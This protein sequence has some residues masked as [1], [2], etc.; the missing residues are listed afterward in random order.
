[1]SEHGKTEATPM[2]LDVLKTFQQSMNSLAEKD[3]KQLAA[4]DA[5]LP[6]SK[7]KESDTQEAVLAIPR[8]PDS[9][10]LPSLAQSQTPPN[11]TLDTLESKTSEPGVSP[12]SSVYTKDRI[13]SNDS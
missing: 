6:G 8:P 1:M 3:A 9:S 12:A 13:K 10:S 7:T 2:T 4:V 11:T 5:A